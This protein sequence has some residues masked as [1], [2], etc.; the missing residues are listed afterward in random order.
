MEVS[1]DL[2]SVE[3]GFLISYELKLPYMMTLNSM[4]R[5]LIKFE[6][7]KSTLDDWSKECF[8]KNFDTDLT[9][10]DVD[11]KDEIAFYYNLSEK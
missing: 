10:N 8:E 7:S 2:L 5:Q 11:L 4:I 1:T 6:S 9:Q 3:K